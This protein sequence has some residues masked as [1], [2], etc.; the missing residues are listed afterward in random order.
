MKVNDWLL[1]IT[2]TLLVQ[3]TYECVHI[4]M[5]NDL[6]QVPGRFQLCKL[7]TV[8]NSADTTWEVDC[9][10]YAVIGLSF[11]LV[12]I[13][14][15]DHLVFLLAA[16][17]DCQG[18]GHGNRSVWLSPIWPALRS[19]CPTHGPFPAL[20]CKISSWHLP[21]QWFVRPLFI[22]GNDGELMLHI[23]I[24]AYLLP[25][26]SR[27]KPEKRPLI[28][29]RPHIAYSSSPTVLT[30]LHDTLTCKVSSK[31]ILLLLAVRRSRAFVFPRHGDSR[32]QQAAKMKCFA[33]WMGFQYPLYKQRY[34]I[35]V[36]GLWL[37]TMC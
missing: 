18:I 8:T 2:E 24:R 3:T 36:N 20:S 5:D 22:H 15:P 26:G 16:K 34:R 13:G 23:M 31:V 27:V 9:A 33:I 32:G 19:F 29:Q 30:T 21:L 11:Q 37:F 7:W 12:H 6:C 1:K 17:R 14:L 35:L 4:H 25:L 10:P 28:S